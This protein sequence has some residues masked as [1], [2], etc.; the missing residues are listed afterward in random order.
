ML[1]AGLGYNSKL[2]S[3]DYAFSYLAQGLGFEHRI[4]LRVGL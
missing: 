4:G 2:F 3:L 1:S